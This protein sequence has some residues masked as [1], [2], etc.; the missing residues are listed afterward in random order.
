MIRGFAARGMAVAA[1]LA[2]LQAATFFPWR[3]DDA[4]NV[5]PDQTSKPIAILLDASGEP[6]AIVDLAVR[7][8]GDAPLQP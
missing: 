2:A 6:L 8:L 3:F 5:S 4:S 1:G 7:G